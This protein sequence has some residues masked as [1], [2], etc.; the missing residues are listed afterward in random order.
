MDEAKYWT[1]VREAA[2]KAARQFRGTGVYQIDARP[3]E[4]S[5]GRPAVRFTVWLKDKP[6][7]ANYV[8]SELSALERRLSERELGA[9]VCTPT[10]ILL[11][12]RR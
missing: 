11:E 1:K 8:W 4:D 9:H 2:T 6:E 10:D 5:L 12:L 7:D 3:Y